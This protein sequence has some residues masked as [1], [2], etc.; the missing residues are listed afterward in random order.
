MK[1]SFK[2][3]ERQEL[4][5]ELQHWNTALQNCLRKPEVPSD[6]SD[7]LTSELLS[8]FDARLCEDA[9]CNAHILH[10]ALAAAWRQK[11]DSQKHFSSLQMRW[12]R[13]GF[14]SA[15]EFLL[16][17]PRECIQQSACEVWQQVLVEV[18]EKEGQ[19]QE[20]CDFDKGFP[21]IRPAI[22]ATEPERPPSPKGFKKLQFLM[23][24]P[25]HRPSK[26]SASQ[27]ITSLDREQEPQDA[28]KLVKV[29]FISNL[30]ALMPQSRWNG[31]LTHP[32]VQTAKIVRLEHVIPQS[33]LQKVPLESALSSPR[34]FL[35]RKPYGGSTIFR[36]DRLAVAAA[37]TWAVL[38]L[39]GTPWLEQSRLRKENIELYIE[40]LDSLGRMKPSSFCFS[41]M[42]ES[43]HVVALDLQAGDVH[44]SEHIRHKT[45]FSLGILLI[46]LALNTSFDTLR[47]EA[48]VGSSGGKISL[49]DDY[50]IA[51]EVIENQVLELEVGESYANAVQRCL[52]CQFLG[53]SSTHDFS[54]ASFRRQFYAGV[55]APVQATYDRE[56][57]SSSLL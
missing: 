15:G 43:P 16:A 38:F 17:M 44:Q 1:R 47:Q 25:V 4:F 33:I 8:R 12:H 56:A 27:E 20:R 53:R 14:G 26:P 7:P 5:R 57:T 19:G 22:L 13:Q 54:H 28:Q 35:Q 41:H 39:S 32:D 9:R 48:Q 45:L 55:V 3:T 51:N 6:E 46:E 34:T 30:C 21:A 2:H 49:A 42:F 11:C 29:R 31:Y 24:N 52:Q 40:H 36:K 10:E 50:A 37:V 18:I 23:P